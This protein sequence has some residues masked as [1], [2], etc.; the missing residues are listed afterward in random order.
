MA[1]AFRNC[2]LCF[3]LLEI[4]S[5]GWDNDSVGE[6]VCLSEGLSSDLQQAQ[7]KLGVAIY[8]CNP[9]TGRTETGELLWVT[10]CQPSWKKGELRVG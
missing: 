4:W 1:V 8:N 3:F 5:S 7:K 9:S 10:A 6:S 2:G